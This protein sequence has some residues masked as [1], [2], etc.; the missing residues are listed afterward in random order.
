MKVI[1]QSGEQTYISDVVRMDQVRPVVVGDYMY[2]NIKYGTTYI[3]L[4]QEQRET[5][6][7]TANYAIQ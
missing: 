3:W 2:G 1:V 6:T 4:E 5:G 7:I